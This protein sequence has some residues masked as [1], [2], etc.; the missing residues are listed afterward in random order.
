[1]QIKS[2]TFD[3]W[4]KKIYRRPGTWKKMSFSHFLV[5][6]IVIAPHYVVIRDN[7]NTIP[8]LC[9]MIWDFEHHPPWKD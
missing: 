4:E 8:T 6:K 2:K 7:I 9:M 1:M 5:I 3:G